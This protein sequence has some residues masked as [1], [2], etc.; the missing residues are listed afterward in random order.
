MPTLCG[1]I[2]APERAQTLSPETYVPPDS[3]TAASCADDV[4]LQKATATAI[5][6]PTISSVPAAS[7]AGPSPTK[8]PAPIINPIPITTASTVVIRRA[9]RS[10]C[11][12]S[13]SGVI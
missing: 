11:D 1:I 5:A 12:R 7:A 4:A 6:S 2:E 8:I 13:S 9:S 10:G 3:E